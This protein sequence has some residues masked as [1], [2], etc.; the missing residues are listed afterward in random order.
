MS[1]ITLIDLLPSDIQE[2]S[3]HL[4]RLLTHKFQNKTEFSLNFR[5][6][7]T[8]A[9]EKGD[10]LSG[11]IHLSYGCNCLLILNN[12]HLFIFDLTRKNLLAKYDTKHN[13]DCIDVEEDV[14]FGREPGGRDSII[15]SFTMNRQYILQKFDLHQFIDAILKNTDP[16]ELSAFHWTSTLTTQVRGMCIENSNSSPA[17][18]YI[19]DT[20]CISI[21]NSTNGQF[22]GQLPFYN[23]TSS[24]PFTFPSIARC[25]FHNQ[26]LYVSDNSNH[27]I[28]ILKKEQKANMD[29]Q[30]HSSAFRLQGTIKRQTNKGINYCSPTDVCIE[31]SNGRIF[32][33]T[34]VSEKDDYGKVM[35]FS[36]EGK[37]LLREE[38]IEK[39]RHICLNRVTN[40]LIA[41]CGRKIEVFK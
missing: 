26:Y 18:I 11:E 17:Y 2:S 15:V 20:E 32:V 10:Y 29:E 7:D 14:T 27:K 34:V 35:V 3:R 16:L 37:T 25:A 19:H 12:D 4:L 9:T 39:L 1:R 33:C 24:I 13:W 8:P 28:Y 30:Q 38:Y 23:A 36:Q 31:E 21:V 5:K 40:E 6:V 22:L 41:C